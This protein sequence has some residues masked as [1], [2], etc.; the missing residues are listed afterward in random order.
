MNRDIVNRDIVNGQLPI[1]PV[2]YSGTITDQ[3]FYIYFKLM[4]D[5]TNGDCDG[6]TLWMVISC[7]GKYPALLLL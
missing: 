4:W 2:L 6:L 3:I 1:A 7:A 5:C